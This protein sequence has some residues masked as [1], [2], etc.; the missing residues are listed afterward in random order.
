MSFGLDVNLLLYASDQ[1]S[2]FHTQARNFLRE[3]SQ[4]PELCYIAWSTLL[5]YVRMATHPRIFSHPLSP[6]LALDN[7]RQLVDR[8]HVR[9]LSEMEGFLDIYKDITSSLHVRGNLVPDAHLVA[10]LRQHDIST[11]YTTD[12]DFRKFSWL[13]VLNPLS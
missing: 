1:T 11:L 7:I 10:L 9:T 12:S 2:P 13:K 5:S 3:A 4:G 8:P 6:T